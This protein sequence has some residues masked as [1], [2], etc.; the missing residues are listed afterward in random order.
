MPY[1]QVTRR[2]KNRAILCPVFPGADTQLIMLASTFVLGVGP[3]LGDK[4]VKL[5][6]LEPVPSSKEH[7]AEAV[8]AGID[9]HESVRQLR[10]RQLE[11][12]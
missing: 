5:I 4:I 6:E 9:E 2:L 11:P 7:P 10:V 12:D 3:A 1:R 8:V